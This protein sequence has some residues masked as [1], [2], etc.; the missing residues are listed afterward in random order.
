MSNDT[1]GFI[2]AAFV[3]GFKNNI[4]MLAQQTDSRLFGKST[5]E[6]QASKMDFYE[7]L[8]PV[9]AVEVTTR[10][11]DTPILDPEHSSR[12]CVLSDAEYGAMI[13]NLDK[14]RLLIQPENAYVSNA[15]SALNRRKDT[16]FIQAALGNSRAGE[17]GSTLVPLP[18]TQKMVAVKED[19]SGHGP[20]N[21]Y[22]LTNVAEKFNSSEIDPDTMKYWAIAPKQL[23]NLLNDEKLTSADYTT[24]KALM[25][26]KID[27]FMGFTFIMSNRLP[28]TAAATDYEV[29]DG[30]VKTGAAGVLPAGARRNFA[31]VEDGMVSA[32][33]TGGFGLRVDVGPRRDKRMSTQI[34][35]VHSVG[36]VRLEEIKVIEI[37][38]AE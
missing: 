30:Q 1:H 18:E 12:A 2:D 24:V 32:I 6:V 7:R 33:G 17:D 14:V 20:L 28:V 36:A 29:A 11:G 5:N 4:Y 37:L 22:T 26:G 34:Y 15:V 38:V 9:E 10:H 27:M 13:D 21:N 25:N 16:I 23:R 31:W 8:A 35:A 19:G 3:D